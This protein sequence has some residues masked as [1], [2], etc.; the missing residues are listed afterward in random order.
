MPCLP[1]S[2]AR[3]MLLV[4]HAMAALADAI[5]ASGVELYDHDGV[6]V[7]LDPNTG[8]RVGVNLAAFRGL[9]DKQICGVRVV[10]RGTG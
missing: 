6:L 10:N 9:I 8:K 1:P 2:V 3:L 4:N 7:S 5:A